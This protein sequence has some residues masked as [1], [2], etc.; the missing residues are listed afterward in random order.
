MKA[1][2]RSLLPLEH[3]RVMD[4][5][6][7]AGVDVSGW[8]DY[9]GGEHRAASNPKYCY[10]WSFHV[11]GRLVVLNIWHAQLRGANGKIT[12]TGNLRE[13]A[14]FYANVPGKSV[15]RKRAEAFDHHVALAAADGLPV[16]TIICDG[17]IRVHLDAEARAS[18]VRARVL[19]SAPWAVRSYKQSSGRFVLLRGALP[20]R[21]ADQFHSVDAPGAPT[22]TRNVAGIVFVRDPSVRRHALVRAAG[23]CEWCGS[24]GFTTDDGSVFLETHHVVPLNEEGPD[25][26]SNVVAVCANHHREAHFGLGRTTMRQRLLRFLKTG[27]PVA[28]AA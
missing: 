28:P 6:R 14:A 15:W 26:V 12:F 24:L 8:G 17:D 18:K 10:E 16:R 22:E 13:S 27:K 25:T 21:L 7:D 2:I 9:K 23:R 5:A 4:L 11:P 19:D 3:P 20:H 1:L